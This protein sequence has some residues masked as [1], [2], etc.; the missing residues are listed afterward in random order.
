MCT[1]AL[2]TLKELAKTLRMIYLKNSVPYLC[3]IVDVSL[4]R[5]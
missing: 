2:P 1:R 5:P 3:G 4:A